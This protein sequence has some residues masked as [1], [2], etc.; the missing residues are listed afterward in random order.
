MDSKEVMR[1]GGKIMEA[2]RNLDWAT[3]KENY[4]DMRLY[5]EE[6]HSLRRKR[7]RFDKIY[8]TSRF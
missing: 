2:Q 7:D 3:A 5:S 1:I 8:E 4:K 6:L